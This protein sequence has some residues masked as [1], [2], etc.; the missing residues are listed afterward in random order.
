M[1]H[2]KEKQSITKV[3]SCINFVSNCR[4][5]RNIIVLSA[6]F[7]NNISQ[8]MKAT[9]YLL[10]K[11]ANFEELVFGIIYIIMIIIF[12]E[13][14]VIGKDSG[15]DIMNVTRKCVYLRSFKLCIKCLFNF[16]I[17]EVTIPEDSIPIFGE[18]IKSLF[19][20]AKHLKKVKISKNITK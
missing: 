2:S 17:D 10:I 18:I 15:F 19:S 20:I 3:I 11:G 6:D 12:A 7:D 14:V 16:T 5:L 9:K 1:F 8:Y 4:R 13:K